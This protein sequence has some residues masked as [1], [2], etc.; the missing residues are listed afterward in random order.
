MLPSLAGPFPVEFDGDAHSCLIFENK[1]DSSE[2]KL[3]LSQIRER[4]A[5]DVVATYPD[6]TVALLYFLFKY[7][8]NSCHRFLRFLVI[9]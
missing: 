8:H 4:A 1:S 7:C 9:E 2:G 5:W 3:T 6:P